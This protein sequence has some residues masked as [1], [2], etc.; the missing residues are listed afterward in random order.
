MISRFI[1]RFTFAGLLALIFAAQAYAE[2]S[3][4]ASASP[5]SVV[6]PSAEA[7]GPNELFPPLPSLASLPPSSADPLDDAAPISA[8]HRGG[9]KARK[10]APRKVVETRAVRVVVSDES[11]AYLADVDRKLD[12]ALRSAPRDAHVIGNAVSVA[13]AR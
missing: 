9:K 11:Q 7:A 13:Q 8:G 12:D 3:A 5:L 2:T 10:G 6:K 1:F 4:S